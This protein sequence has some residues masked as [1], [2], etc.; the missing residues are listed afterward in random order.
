MIVSFNSFMHII[1]AI[2]SKH[3]THFTFGDSFGGNPV[4][5][6]ETLLIMMWKLTLTFINHLH[7]RLNFFV[8]HYV[9][10]IVDGCW[11]CICLFHFVSFWVLHRFFSLSLSRSPHSMYF[12]LRFFQIFQFCRFWRQYAYTTTETKQK[13]ITFAFDLLDFSTCSLYLLHDHFMA[14]YSG[15]CSFLVAF[16]LLLLF[17]FFLSFIIIIHYSFLFALFHSH[18]AIH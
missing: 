6:W 11:H 14:L 12:C 4:R 16:I 18:L 9:C 1:H 7:F 13:Q 3:Y 8:I 15:C 5:E 17:C 10:G 2:Y